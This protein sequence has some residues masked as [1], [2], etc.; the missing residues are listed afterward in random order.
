MNLMEGEKE[1][2]SGEGVIK[3]LMITGGEP[4]VAL[5]GEGR[6]YLTN[7]RLIMEKE[8]LVLFELPLRAVQEASVIGTIRRDLVV[9]ADL[10]EMKTNLSKVDL[11]RLKGASGTFLIEVDGPSEW[12]DEI[13]SATGLA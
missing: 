2:K 1:L 9:D 7:K 12:A 5:Q 13:N 4:E 8:S 11:S 3:E 10:S 6:L